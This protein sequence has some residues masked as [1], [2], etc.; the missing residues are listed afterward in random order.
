MGRHSVSPEVKAEIKRRTALG[1]D[2]RTLAKELKVSATTIVRFS[3]RPNR[4]KR[5]TW[6]EREEESAAV[7]AI[8]APAVIRVDGRCSGDR[9][10]IFPAGPNGF[11]RMHEMDRKA[12][13]SLSPSTMAEMMMVGGET[14]NQHGF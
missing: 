14:Q 13:R 3:A 6:I 12:E 10:C 2:Y 1:D 8:V 9:A 5:K 11:C 4:A 7:I